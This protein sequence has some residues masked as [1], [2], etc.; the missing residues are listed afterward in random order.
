MKVESLRPP[1]LTNA[2]FSSATGLLLAS[3]SPLVATSLGPQLNWFYVL[4]GVGLL[5]FS[6]TLGVITMRPTPL[7]VVAVIAADL[8]WVVSTTMALLVWRSD[9]TPMGFALVSGVNAIVL[10]IAWLQQNSIRKAFRAPGGLPDEYEVC[11]AAD[12]P[13]NAGA[14]WKVL[15]EIGAI[16]RYMP[17]LKSSALTVGE[18][19]GPGCVRTCENL[20]GQVWSEKCEE[21]EEG[22]SF[23]VVFLTDQPGF[24]YPFSKMRGGWRVLPTAT[25]CQ[26]QVWWRVVPR[27]PWAA[28]LLLPVM[29]TGA[30][31]DF[32]D[33]IARMSLE[34]KG[35]KPNFDMRPA[36]PRLSA[37]FC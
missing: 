16:Q 11:I 1:L 28:A 4:I 36:L 27:H 18:K 3:A 8:G 13:V 29:A 7:L 9:F 14:F 21:W 5:L 2:A 24:P 35:V 10:T 6:A 20:K 17:A 23:T 31:R 34:A 15:A 30:Q 25:G 26:V 37:A 32:T 33:V 22:K 12:A 19:P